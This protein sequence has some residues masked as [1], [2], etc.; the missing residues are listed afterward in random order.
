[1]IPPT[2]A[3]YTLTLQ[4]SLYNCQPIVH[5]PHLA[6]HKTLHSHALQKCTHHCTSLPTLL[7]LKRIFF[8]S[9][10][11]CHILKEAEN[12]HFK[13]SRSQICPCS[14]R[15]GC[16][17]SHRRLSSARN[18]DGS[19]RARI[20]AKT[21]HARLP[22]DNKTSASPENPQISHL[23][24]T[25]V[26]F[27]TAIA[28]IWIGEMAKWWWWFWCLERREAFHIGDFKSWHVAQGTR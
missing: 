17:K 21:L 18:H 16:K 10:D 23:G 26:S 20:R 28:F 5:H 3:M 19:V 12:G 6:P 11:I 7:G 8:G 22:K 13:A 24:S 15:D 25:F 4:S 2:T 9:W 1:M 14:P 27:N